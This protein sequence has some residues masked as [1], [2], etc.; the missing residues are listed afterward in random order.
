MLKY[1]YI[2]FMQPIFQKTF[3]IDEKYDNIFEI[4]KK[5]KNMW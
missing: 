5:F 1:D 2:K 4:W 3:V